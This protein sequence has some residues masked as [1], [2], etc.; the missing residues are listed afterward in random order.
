[1][2]AAP[3]ASPRPST[4]E[5]SPRAAEIV[6]A[7]RELLAAEGPAGLTMRRLAERLSIRAP[8]LYKHLPDKGSLEALVI[9]AGLFEIGDALHQAVR[10]R[11]SRSP[12]AALLAT[13]RRYGSRH[14]NLYRLT[15]DAGFPRARLLPGL[16]DWA[17]EP[18]LLATGEPYVA[19]ALWAFAHGTMILELDQ[20]FQ[21]GSDLDR[22]WAAGVRA[23]DPSG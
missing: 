5:L 17:G 1:M 19:Q 4:R 23:F 15:T 7:A 11:G 6:G 12:V 18:F 9:E 2:S 21:T 3:T 22:T 10:E 8:S 14:P 16:E 13:Y 20:R